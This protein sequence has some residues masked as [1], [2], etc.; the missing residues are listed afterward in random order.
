MSTKTALFSIEE[1]TS[2]YEQYTDATAAS[3]QWAWLQLQNM[4]LPAAKH[5]EWRYTPL[6]YM[7]RRL[8]EPAIGSA[9]AGMASPADVDAYRFIFE[10][11]QPT[12]AVMLETPDFLLCTLRYAFE[13]YPEQIS[14]Y[15]AHHVHLREEFFVLFN[16]ALWQE[17]IFLWVKKGK[18][19]DKP[20]MTRFIE[21]HKQKLCQTRNLIVLEPGA[22][23]TWIATHES[24]SIQHSLHNQVNELYLENDAQLCHY[25]FEQ[26]ALANSR[27]L[28]TFAQLARQSYYHNVTLVWGGDLLRHDLCVAIQG[29]AAQANLY[30]LNVVKGQTHVDHHTWVDH[31]A[32]KA[33]SNELYKG[34]YDEQ[35]VGV[36][37]GKIYVRPDAQQTNAFQSNRNI[38]LSP[39]ANVNTKPQLE[40]WAD[41]VK[42]SHGA[43]IGQIDEEALF[44]LRS[45]GIGQEAAKALLLQAFAQEVVLQILHPELR[46]Q[47]MIYLE[48]LLS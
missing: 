2:A 12:E 20:L 37:N 4:Q 33:Y 35:S 45:R 30:G 38:L 18:S 32:P 17:G 27:I 22:Q 15:F 10:D 21:R 39:V 41:D 47:A 23:A 25:T 5:E 34:I 1:W 6:H 29:E 16:Q 26:Q 3:R 44:Y 42:C 8:G 36:F 14:R 48:S 24:D 28:R 31:I 11:G 9:R 13:H 19:L 7:W 46:Q 40:I 43:T